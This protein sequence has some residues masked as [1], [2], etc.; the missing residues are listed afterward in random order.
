VSGELIKLHWPSKT[1][2]KKTLITPH[3]IANDP[4]P[5]GNT[6]GGRG[7]HLLNDQIIVASYDTLTLFD[8]DLN[9][10][11][12]L[13]HFLMAGLH[14]ICPSSDKSLWITSTDIDAVLE[15]DMASRSMVCEYWPREMPH[16]Q[17]ALSLYPRQINKQADNRLL[18][19][20][21]RPAE[22]TH[23]HLNACYWWQGEMYALFNTYGVVA[24]LSRDE[25]VI[26]DPT[27]KGSHNLMIID[28]G[29]IFIN[30]SWGRTI[31]LY[32]IYTRQ[33][34]RL[35]DL[36]HFKWVRNLARKHYLGYAA[37][38]V[39]KVLRMGRIPAARPIFVRG[40]DVVDEYVFV[41][42]SPVAILQ[43][44]WRTE[45]L[46]DTFHYTT[47]VHHSVHGLKVSV[48]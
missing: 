24:N 1:I 12:E 9:Q 29:T 23:L 34:K 15:Y 22:D 13:S 30:D 2:L 18:Y 32:D 4:N 8:P 44:N 31:R 28:D 7:I 43:I 5:R 20:E 16:L 10:Q 41:G 25:V 46:V 17:E 6:R 21:S 40:L 47:D 27:L 48:A 38:S 39:R 33:Q 11:G 3:R 19:L 35:I 45:T 14:E 42:I 37:K 26:Q 36:T